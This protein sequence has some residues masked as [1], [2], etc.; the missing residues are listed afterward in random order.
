MFKNLIGQEQVKSALSF[1]SA[2]NEA[3]GFVPPLGFWGP[4]GTGKTHFARE[5]S[6]SIKNKDG[7]R[8]PLLEVNCSTLK[9]VSD[10]FDSIVI[11]FLL[12]N[13]M[14]VFF[15]LR[16]HTFILATT[17][18]DKIFAPLKD[19]LE[20]IDFAPYT[21]NELKDIFLAHVDKKVNFSDEA[22]ANIVYSSR[23]VPRFAVKLAR[24]ISLMCA[25]Q[26]I[27]NFDEQSFKKFLK[28]LKIIS[29][30]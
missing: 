3:K 5:F 22:L 16:Q 14:T 11:P 29:Y 19:R 20:S 8:R 9:K 6:H 25:A 12:N 21:D 7:S 26:N 27:K 1:Y 2:G 17:E 23:E 18:S 30:K 24:D 28:N 13:E 15:D 10:F 4:A